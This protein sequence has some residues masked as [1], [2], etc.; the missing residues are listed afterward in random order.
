MTSI[1]NLDSEAREPQIVTVNGVA[2]DFGTKD[3]TYLQGKTPSSNHVLQAAVISQLSGVEISP[4][5]CMAFLAMHRFIQKS[6]AN[7]ARPE[8]HGRTWESVIRGS[9]TLAE[10]A[11]AQPLE[12][13]VVHAPVGAPVEAPAPRRARKSTTT[14][15]TRKAPAKAST[16]A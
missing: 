14:R 12:G 1:E 16:A 15:R 11:S 10:R 3:W 8:Y 2:Y 13:P 6:E 9:Q 7:Q 4:E 5:Q